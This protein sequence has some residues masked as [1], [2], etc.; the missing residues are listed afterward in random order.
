MLNGIAENAFVNMVGWSFL[1]SMWQIAIIAGLLYLTTTAMRR[2]SANLRYLVSLFALIL[3][4]AAP[5]LT[6]ELQSNSSNLPRQT[7]HPE[8]A[9]STIGDEE[10]Q[11][12]LT[13]KLNGQVEKVPA[14]DATTS[15]SAQLGKRLSRIVPEILPWIVI[16][17]LAGVF[18]YTVRF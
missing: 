17:W 12:V 8:T 5:V 13:R 7:S 16:L 2:S 10:Q 4:F 3:A 14:S 1:H 15:A 18:G 6:V 11:I 9:S